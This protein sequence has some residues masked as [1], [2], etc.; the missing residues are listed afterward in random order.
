MTLVRKVSV[1]RR[2]RPCLEAA[3]SGGSGRRAC[4][5]RSPSR[6]GACGMGIRGEERQNVQ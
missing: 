2:W 1:E 6:K 5:L 4:F 3:C